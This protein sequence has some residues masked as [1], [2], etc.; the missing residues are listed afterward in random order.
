MASSGTLSGSALTAT[1]AQVTKCEQNWNWGDWNNKHRTV[2]CTVQKLSKEI[3]GGS[4]ARPPESLQGKKNEAP[5][6][7]VGYK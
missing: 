4:S 6:R 5:G 3:K 7:Q 1:Q 2:H